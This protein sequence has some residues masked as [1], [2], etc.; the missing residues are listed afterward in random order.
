MS[1][2]KLFRRIPFVVRIRRYFVAKAFLQDV[3]SKLPQLQRLTST[4]G[5]QFSKAVAL[6]QQ[7]MSTEERQ[8]TTKIEQ[9]RKRLLQRSGP[10]VDG[11]IDGEIGL[12]DK[13]LTVFQTCQASKPP[14]QARLLFALTRA[15]NPVSVIELG[16]NVGIS[17]AYI[18][19]A[20]KL[21]GRG[22]KVM[23]LDA[24]PYR[25]RL[26]KEIHSNLGLDNVSYRV[27][28]F[29]D[30]LEPSL[31]ELENVD[32]AFIDGHH[33]YQPTLDY[34]EQ[35]LPF[36]TDEAIFAF[37]DIAW[38]DGMKKAWREL[39]DDKRFALTA[40]LLAIGLCA[41]GGDEKGERIHV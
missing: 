34:F 12:Y 18:A 39:Q 35:I 24:S 21:N 13:G 1:L 38:S 26:A 41:L 27:G 32:L 37:D 20:L 5:Q 19:A 36:A 11:S 31:N 17:S 6:M 7:P 22:G 29:S 3:S 25:Q 16:T 30:T 14:E 40:D 10:L 4:R 23:T 8:W 15:V 9:E 2:K 33:Q 28:L